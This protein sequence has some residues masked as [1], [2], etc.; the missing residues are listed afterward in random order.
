MVSIFNFFP[1]KNIIN[2]S[3]FKK[4]LGNAAFQNI[5]SGN[6]PKVFFIFSSQKRKIELPKIFP[7]KKRQKFL[8][9]LLFSRNFPQIFVVNFFRDSA[10]Y[11]VVS[12]LSSVS[13]KW[14]GL[15]CDWVISGSMLRANRGGAISDGPITAQEGSDHV[16][17]I[18]LTK[19][20]R[21]TPLY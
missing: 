13:W 14:G 20:T 6:F 4:F 9:L 17:L 1:K 2:F 15:G 3:Y 21:H 18:N 7:T 10:F 19:R 16:T 11:N 5:F 8:F 12:F